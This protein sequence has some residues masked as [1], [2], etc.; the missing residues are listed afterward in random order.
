LNSSELSLNSDHSNNPTTLAGLVSRLV[1][2]L[3]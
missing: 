2:I 3:S 1:E